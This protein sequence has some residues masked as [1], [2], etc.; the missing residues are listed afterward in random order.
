MRSQSFRRLISM[1]AFESNVETRQAGINVVPIK[2]SHII[3]RRVVRGHPVHIASRVVVK[4]VTGA[5]PSATV[6]R[7]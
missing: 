5:R 2:R 1:V 7:A 4:V 6:Y 3:R